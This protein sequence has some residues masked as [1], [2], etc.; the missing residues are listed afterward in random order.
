[1]TWLFYELARNPQIYAKL[2]REVLQAVG[3]T[4]LPTYEDL[5]KIKY[6]RDT[7]SETLRLYPPVSF[8]AR[9]TLNASS[10]PEGGVGPSCNSKDPFSRTTRPVGVLPGTLIAYSPLLLHRDPKHYPGNSSLSPASATPPPSVFC[11][12]RWENWSPQPWRYLPFNGGPRICV[13]QNF[14]LTEIAYATARIVQRFSRLELT[15]ECRLRLGE[16]NLK[17]VIVLQPSVP[18]LCKFFPAEAE[19]K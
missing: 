19:D 18:I 1:M 16:H 11:P 17:S 6:L 9:Y 8:N 3:S 14:A 4:R 2:R 5:K 7:I 12:E 15:A 13:G 10:L